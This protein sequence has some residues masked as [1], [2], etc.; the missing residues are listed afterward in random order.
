LN[1]AI[2][3]GSVFVGIAVMLLMSS[4]G[5][6][7]AVG[8]WK[9]ALDCTTVA[10]PILASPSYWN[11]NPC[12][13]FLLDELCTTKGGA[14]GLTSFLD[15]NRDEIKQGNERLKCFKT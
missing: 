9:L 4:M 6:A 2:L 10:D 5:P 8:G 12:G 7:F 13:G 11:A 1:R 3:V 14:P 15:K